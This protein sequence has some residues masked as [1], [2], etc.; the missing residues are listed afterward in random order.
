MKAFERFF[1]DDLIGVRFAINVFIGT[2]NPINSSDYNPNNAA[3]TATGNTYT[4]TTGSTANRGTAWVPTSVSGYTYT[5]DPTSG[6]EAA[7]RAGARPQ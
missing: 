2:A 6:V 3:V 5:L 4:S 7:V 1:E